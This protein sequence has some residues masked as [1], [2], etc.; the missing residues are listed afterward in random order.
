[1]AAGLPLSRQL[2]D[3]VLAM[4]KYS[5]WL[6]Q[7]ILSDD[8]VQRATESGRG[9]RVRDEQE[10][11]AASTV[12]QVNEGRDT[13]SATNGAGQNGSSADGAAAAS[14]EDGAASARDWIESWRE[15][16]KVAVGSK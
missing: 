7:E 14:T 16:Q 2:P 8:R 12:T 3:C 1:M 10:T 9:R 4:N 15:R 11:E 13:A 6:A 5:A